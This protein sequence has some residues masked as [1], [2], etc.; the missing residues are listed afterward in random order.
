M[1]VLLPLAAMPLLA[2]LLSRLPVIPGVLLSLL[3]IGVCGGLAASTFARLTAR[4]RWILLS[5]LII[6]TCFTPG[7]SLLPDMPELPFTYEG[8]LGSLLQTLHL[9]AMLALVACV[10]QRYT[11]QQLL[12]GLY[13]GLSACRVPEHALQRVVARLAL[14]MAMQPL[15]TSQQHRWQRQHWLAYFNAPESLMAP[16]PIEAVQLQ[17]SPLR[18]V[19]RFLLWVMLGLIPLLLVY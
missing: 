19:E 11:T 10:L 14:I 18:A 6:Y 15:I 13:Q 9:M 3:V 12:S 16:L 2:V 5:M 1:H 17:F 7:E 4:L 8:L